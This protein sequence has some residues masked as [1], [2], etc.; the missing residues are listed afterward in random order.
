ML[1]KVEMILLFFLIVVA[2]SACPGKEQET[3]E[4]KTQHDSGPLQSDPLQMATL[5]PTVAPT[6][7]VKPKDPNEIVS[8]STEILNKDEDRVHNIKVAAE[9]IDHTVLEPDEVFSFNDILGKRT[10]DKGYEKA[11]ILLGNGEKGEGTGG[12]ICQV[13]TTLYNAALK[14]DFKI[15]ERHRHSEPI[16]YVEEGKDATVVYNSKDLRFKNTRDYPVEILI[17]VSEDKV[18]VKLFK[19]KASD[20]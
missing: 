10:G 1:K 16:P 5:T 8:F 3:P 11:P 6:P 7:S 2:F 12:G 15:V 13:S 19:K 18:T 20:E 9:E 14:A 17:H 4:D